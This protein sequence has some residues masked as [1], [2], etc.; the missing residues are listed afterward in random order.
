MS[1]GG[2]CHDLTIKRCIETLSVKADLAHIHTSKA[3]IDE[4]YSEIKNSVKQKECKKYFKNAQAA[5]RNIGKA[6][7]EFY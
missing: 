6:M 5:W 1:S 2:I 3:S 7:Q 4:K